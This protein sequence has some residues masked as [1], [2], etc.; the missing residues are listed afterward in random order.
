MFS[1]MHVLP[2]NS[3]LKIGPNIKKS[4]TGRTS[5]N[6]LNNVQEGKQSFSTLNKDLSPRSLQTLNNHNEA[7]HESI[8]TDFKGNNDH[9]KYST[10][11]SFSNNHSFLENNK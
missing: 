7:G 9:E 8:S 4:T 5:Q 3:K 6:R 11:L 10:N 2:K 1:K